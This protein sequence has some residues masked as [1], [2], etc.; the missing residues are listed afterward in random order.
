MFQKKKGQKKETMDVWKFENVSQ[1]NSLR[2]GGGH[3]SYST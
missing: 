3:D 2:G 1:G